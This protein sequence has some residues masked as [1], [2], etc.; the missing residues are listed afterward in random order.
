[1]NAHEY[2][3]MYKRH[4]EWSGDDNQGGREALKACTCSGIRGIS[5]RFHAIQH[6]YTRFHWLSWFYM[7]SFYCFTP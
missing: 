2:T 3:Y 5:A 1:M 4:P 7:Y 6:F